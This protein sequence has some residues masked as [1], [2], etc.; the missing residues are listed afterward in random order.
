MRLTSKRL[1]VTLLCAL[2]SPLF[3]QT[4]RL[5]ATPPM[6]WNSWNH[7]N[8]KVTDADVRAAAD[9][10]VSSGMRDAGYL[11]VNIDD[12]WE[13]G[14]D[15]QGNIQTNSKFP[16]MKALG[17][18]IHSKGLKFGIYSSPGPRTCA[19]FEGSYNHEQQDA[20][21]YAKWGVDYLKYDLCSYSEI[22][23]Q[24]SNGD[25]KAA[26]QIMH[27]AYEKM[28]QAL[29]KTNRPIVY[30]LCQY[31]FDS[32][33]KWGPE[34]GGN[35]WRTTDDIS[36]NWNSMTAIG[37]QQAGLSRYAGPGHWNDPDMLEVGNGRMKDEEYRVHM[38]LWSLLA[39]PLLAG[40]DLSKMTPETVSILTNKE[41][42]ALDQDALGKQ[43]DRVSAVGPFEIWS[44]QLADGSKAVALFNRGEAAS[45]MTL[46]LKEV[47]IT[48]SVR[49][50]DLWQHKDLGTIKD[51]YT[52]DVPRHGVLLLK[53]Q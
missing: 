8:D 36:D 47:G 24:Q 21:S 18:Y 9:Y 16:D 39:A 33:W 19:N 25:Q 49:A 6:G 30:S 29:L 40:N 22:M 17:D 12:T 52:A 31:G 2:A 32:V 46:N 42:I 41:V 1:A 34:V 23:K 3:A 38:S 5:A 28:H 44:K 14:R 51:S 45:P 13:A 50:R 53:L 26:W 37:F 43:G 10:I 27:Q 35:S 4:T 48:H 15:A 7:F 20:D 11:Y